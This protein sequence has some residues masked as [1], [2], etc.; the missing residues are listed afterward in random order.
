[1]HFIL[2][3]L[4]EPS[5]WSG[6]ASFAIALG[7]GIPPGTLEAVTQIGIGVAGLAGVLLSER[8]AANGG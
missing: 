6:L 5:T 3:R 4:R 1:M 2:N 7:L 8:G